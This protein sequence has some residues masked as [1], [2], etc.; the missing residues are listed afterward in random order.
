MWRITRRDAVTV[1]E[2][3]NVKASLSR[4]FAVM[5][6]EKPAKF[7]IAKK[8]DVDFFE[9]GSVQELWRIHEQKLKEFARLEMEL[10]N[11]RI[12]LKVFE[13]PKTSF[14]DLKQKIV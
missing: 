8:I 2:D 6:D 4:Y 12:S 1:L 13:N 5:K 14:L 9:V 3:E 7:Q 10:D 11:N